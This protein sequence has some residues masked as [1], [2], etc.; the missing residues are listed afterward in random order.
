MYRLVKH[1]VPIL[2]LVS[3]VSFAQHR[4]SLAIT[5][6]VTAAFQMEPVVAYSPTAARV[7]VEQQDLSGI[8]VAFQSTPASKALIQEIVLV[9]ALRTNAPAYRLLAIPS[10]PDE[11]IE[12]SLVPIAQSGSGAR[13]APTALA[14]FRGVTGFAVSSEDLPIATGTRISMGGRFPSPDN[15]ILVE[16]R[17]VSPA[18]SQAS[19][20]LRLVQ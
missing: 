10:S 12:I 16:I 15:A 5:G 3:T 7:R 17:M 9:V 11:P 6:S 14:G 4:S 1:V 8:S 19:L 2:L 13:V 18:K 20:T